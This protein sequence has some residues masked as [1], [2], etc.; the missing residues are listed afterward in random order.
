MLMTVASYSFPYQAQIARARLEVDG[1][2]AY[3]ADEHTI[4]MQWLYSDALGGVKVQVREQ[5]LSRARSI[6]AED[7]SVDAMIVAAD[8][9]PLRTTICCEACGGSQLEPCSIG[10]RG[11]WSMFLLLQ[12]PLW[13]FRRTLRCRDCGEIGRY[14][15]SAL[16]GRDAD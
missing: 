10:V 8:D 14:S 7:L 6:L 2:Q 15:Q 1:I 12:F 16:G 5:D 3:V 9:K 11:A 4:T 13:P